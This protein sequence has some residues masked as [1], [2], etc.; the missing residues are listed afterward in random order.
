[1]NNSLL[2]YYYYLI[3]NY[4]S[5][6]NRYIIILIILLVFLFVFMYIKITNRFWSSQ[7]VFHTYNLWY[8]LFPPGIVQHKIPKKGKYL[9][10]NI[11][12]F[13]FNNSSKNIKQ[14][15]LYFIQSNCNIKKN[16]SKNN[17]LNLIIKKDYI[18]EHLKNQKNF[19]FISLQYN[20]YNKKLV[21]ALTSRLLN[22]NLDNKRFFISY[23]DNLYIHKKYLNS[24]FKYKQIYTHYVKSR[25][26]GAP[27]I[28]LFKQRKKL[29]N[30]VPFIKFNSYLIKTQNITR[31]N[32]NLPNTI[33]CYR[34]TSENFNILLD[35]IPIIEDNFNFF[36]ISPLSVIKQLIHKNILF[37]FVIKN[38]TQ[39]IGII[40]YKKKNLFYKNKEILECVSSYC[41]SIY[42]TFF[43][44]SI[45][46]TLY[47]LKKNIDFSLVKFDAIADN[48]F[49]LNNLVKFNKPLEIHSNFYYFYNFIYKS[50]NND[51]TFILI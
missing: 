51:K 33:I 48:I 2:N 36:L 34:I 44:N 40:F 19:S 9:D 5:F 46:N 7:P 22:A 31:P 38:N 17:N 16:I 26:I 35:Y 14:Q 13:I 49:L 28:F 1:M 10:S 47:I 12:C 45:T 6:V 20:G 11:E 41:S 30:V 27:P 25:N 23:M 21:G 29:K 18:F 15:L 4:F 3:Y 42:K 37:P 32:I 43:I 8:R 39:L 50:V 24:D